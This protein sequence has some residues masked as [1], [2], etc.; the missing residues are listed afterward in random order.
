MNRR[1]LAAIALWLCLPAWPAHAQFHAT[2]PAGVS[3]TDRAATEGAWLADRGVERLPPLFPH[4]ETNEGDEP[5]SMTLAVP[6]PDSAADA[7]AAEPID[8]AGIVIDEILIEPEEIPKLWSGS[9]DMGIN[10]S[11]GNTSV[12]NFRFNANSRRETERTI[13]TVML[14]YVRDQAEGQVTA[15]RLFLDARNE[16]RIKRSRWTIYIHET[17]EY[18]ES[19]PYDVRLTGDAGL[20]Y[21]FIENERTNLAGRLGPGVSREIGGPDD[22]FIPE[23]VFNLSF[24]HQL[25]ARQALNLSTDY[26]PD[27]A[28]WNNY[29]LNTQ[30]AWRIVLDDTANLSLKFSAINRYDSTVDDQP[31]ELDYAATILWSY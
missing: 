23:L 2:G 6:E 29:R 3:A 31:N 7:I 24:E 11:E 21:R 27:V 15:N 18:D 9:F 10:G 14:N 4:A 30:A 17:T 13:F 8:G 16:W 20:G 1:F 28:N 5:S 19:R 22:E 26:F 25:T 12:F